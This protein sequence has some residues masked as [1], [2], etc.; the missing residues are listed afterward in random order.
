MGGGE[1]GAPGRVWP[2]NF[3]GRGS[4]EDAGGLTA[5]DY[6]EHP[7]PKCSFLQG[8]RWEW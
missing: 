2:F 7:V 1:L 4:F 5:L 3:P 6:G 8:T